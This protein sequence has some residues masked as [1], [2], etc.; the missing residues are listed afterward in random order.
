MKEDQDRSIPKDALIFA[1]DSDDVEVMQSAEIVYRELRARG[2]SVLLAISPGQSPASIEV[3]IGSAG[4]SAG[5]NVRIVAHALQ[6]SE[7][8]NL[9]EV[10]EKTEELIKCARAKNLN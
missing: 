9:E 1:S 4:L 3:H 10:V 8:V 7:W 2:F 5:G 6:T